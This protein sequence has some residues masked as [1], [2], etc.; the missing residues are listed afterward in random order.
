MLS[1]SIGSAEQRG[2]LLTTV[3]LADNSTALIYFSNYH[4]IWQNLPSSNNFK[5]LMVFEFVYSRSKVLSKIKFYLKTD[6]CIYGVIYPTSTSSSPNHCISPKR[7]SLMIFS[8]CRPTLC[9]I[10]KKYVVEVNE[11]L[12]NSI[13]CT[14]LFPGAGA[15]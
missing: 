14:F 12:G 6:I 10:F 1:K 13:F 15:V 4:W 11:N 9:S 8:I 7:C 5:I 3:G 2:A